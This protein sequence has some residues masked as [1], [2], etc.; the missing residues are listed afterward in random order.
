MLVIGKRITDKELIIEN[1]IKE[2]VE[3]FDTISKNIPQA[4]VQE[5]GKTHELRLN[6]ETME[7]FWKEIN[8]ELTDSEKIIALEEQNAHMIFAL[9]EKGVL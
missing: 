8:R 2:D 4:P 9:V 1:I 3:V 5:V 6:T 7:L